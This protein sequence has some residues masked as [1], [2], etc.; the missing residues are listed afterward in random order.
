M[1]YDL[2]HCLHS[3]LFLYCSR[4]L[5]HYFYRAMLRGA[6]NYHGMSI[7][8]SVCLSV[9]LSVTLSYCDHIGRN[10]S[11]INVSWLRVLALLRSHIMDLLQGEHIEI[12]TGIE[13]GTEKW[14]S[15]YKSSDVSE[16]QQDS[17]KVTIEVRQD[18]PCTLNF[19]WC[20]NQR[21]WMTFK[22]HYA[23]CFKTHASFGAHR[24]NLNEDRSILSATKM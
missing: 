3:A 5:V 17:T 6:R 12:L 13:L 19:D 10:S 14:L 8:L 23:L 2:W 4:Y 11:K 18:V 21:P 1:Y 9:R 20:Q 22:G 7:W 24:E 15:A 16:T